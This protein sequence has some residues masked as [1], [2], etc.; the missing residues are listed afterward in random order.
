MH[1]GEHSDRNEGGQELRVRLCAHP[2][3]RMPRKGCGLCTPNVSEAAYTTSLVEALLRV[4]L[5]Q[6]CLLLANLK[7]QHD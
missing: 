2:T 5:T 1:H 4:L 7:A 3:G 6:H